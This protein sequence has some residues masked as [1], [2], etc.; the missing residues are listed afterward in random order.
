MSKICKFLFEKNGMNY[1][2]GLASIH[3]STTYQ[4]IYAP[5]TISGYISG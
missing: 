3:L 5:L 2:T 4:L 1:V